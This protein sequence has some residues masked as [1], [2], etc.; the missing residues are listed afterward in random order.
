MKKK[1]QILKEGKERSAFCL[2]RE[3][4]LFGMQRGRPGTSKKERISVLWLGV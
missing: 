3:V 2:E 1:G 4:G